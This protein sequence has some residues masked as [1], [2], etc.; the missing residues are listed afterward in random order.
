MKKE[1]TIIGTGIV[2]AIAASLCC[3]TPVLALLAGTSGIASAFSWIEP[4]RPYL[5]GLTIIALGFA[6]YQK[7]KPQKKD[8]CGCDATGK[9]KFIQTKMFLGLVTVFAVIMMAFPYYS[10]IFY[11]KN[12]KQGI[13]VDKSTIQAVELKIKG[14]TCAACEEH[15]KHEVNK[16]AGIINAE[17]SYTKR[18][19]IVTFDSSITNTKVIEKAVNTTGYK[20]VESKIK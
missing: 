2:T 18:N 6:W 20:V 9:P 19:A 8:E 17:V 4:F 7:L 10:N 3:I 13:V 15:V 14:M 11:S 1:N 12:D 16:L 5:I